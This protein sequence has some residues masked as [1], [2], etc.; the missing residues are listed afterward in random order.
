MNPCSSRRAGNDPGLAPSAPQ[1]TASQPGHHGAGQRPGRVKRRKTKRERNSA[2]FGRNAAVGGAE[3]R[4]GCRRLQRMPAPGWSSHCAG[5]TKS[6]P[7]PAI[8][9]IS[10]SVPVIITQHRLTQHLGMFNREVKSANIE[11][12]LD[13]RS[14]RETETE[15]SAAIPGAISQAWDPCAP[16]QTC[17]PDTQHGTSAPAPHAAGKGPQPT[18]APSHSETAAVE[19]GESQAE[20]PAPRDEKE[21]VP[22]SGAEPGG[23]TAAM[24]ELAQELQTHLDLTSTFPGRNL[25]SERR[26][27]ILSTLLDRHQTLPD[28]SALMVHNKPGGGSAQGALRSPGAR[29]QELLLDTGSSGSGN[30]EQGISGKRRRG[31]EVLAFRSPSPVH[32]V[33]KTGERR[34]TRRD[35]LE[36]LGACELFGQPPTAAPSHHALLSGSALHACTIATFAPQAPG[37]LPR[38][39]Q[40]CGRSWEAIWE[41]RTRLERAS[42]AFRP[43]RKARASEGHGQGHWMPFAAGDSVRTLGLGLDSR[44]PAECPLAKPPQHPCAHWLSPELWQVL[45][46]QTQSKRPAPELH[47]SQPMARAAP[48][49]QT[50]FDVLKSIW[51]PNQPSQAAEVLA[52]RALAWPRPGHRAVSWELCSEPAL[53]PQACS[54]HRPGPHLEPLLPPGEA[55]KPR[56]ANGL[57]SVLG[58]PRDHC[59]KPAS[60]EPVRASTCYQ[61]WDSRAATPRAWELPEAMGEGCPRA[62]GWEGRFP[63]VGAQQLCTLQQLPMSFFP[64]S[65]A[66]EHGRSPPPTLHGYRLEEGSPEAW[67][68]PRMRLY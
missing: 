43:A 35:D 42:M 10:G 33:I 56:H 64:P 5:H 25:I 17:T 67:V 19:T 18:A 38:A 52:P 1:L 62:G 31:Q 13:P 30:S 66:L 36:S 68:F 29:G 6:T 3:Q 58:K 54:Q 37:P 41:P 4:S 11:R 40:C 32:T 49:T 16:G 15:T 47:A 65:E 21:N 9:R 26:Q 8:R 45:Q 22:P 20:V 12:L 50:S 44:S 48:E 34:A 60:V 2:K 61:P 24:R 28:L 55:R 27:T 57:L 46:T 53:L 51:S 14:E 39:G 7:L 59:Q 23:V 63:P